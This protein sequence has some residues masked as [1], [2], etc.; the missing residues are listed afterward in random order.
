MEFTTARE[1][2]LDEL[3]LFAGVVD[4]KPDDGL[5]VFSNVTFSPIES[6][7][8]LVASGG[9]IGQ[10]SSIEADSGGEGPISL[11]LDRLVR[12]LTASEGDSVVFEE[13]EE[14]WI[15]AKCGGKTSRYPT[16]VG[17]P[18]EVASPPEQA[19]AVVDADLL[20]QLLRTGSYAFPV[21][22]EV[23][24]TNAGAQLELEGSQVRTVSSDHSRLAYSAAD[25]GDESGN[26]E[27]RLLS[28][29]LKTISQ[30]QTLA[31]ASDGAARVFEKDN[32]L[33]FEFGK[34]LLV[35]SKLADRLPD[36]D[37]VIPR[38]CPIFVR[39]NR[40]LLLSSVRAAIP[41]A[42]GEFN[43]ARLEIT[44]EQIQIDASSVHGEE[45]SVLPIEEARGGPLT[46]NVNL[47]HFED[48]A[49]S[50][51]SEFATLEFQSPEKAFILRPS[52]GSGSGQGNDRFDHFCVGMP[53]V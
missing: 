12:W 16:R 7:C 25:T 27:K 46:L 14:H 15:V 18:P 4:R 48:F 1:H 53:L 52:D 32:H 10:R 38:N 24:V 40:D 36:Y 6:G 34:R 3:N 49:K 47:L 35:C 13:T 41:F 50:F 45:T 17:D 31:R 23:T 51:D 21:G 33:F 26:G 9:E 44:E 28:L 8:S 20:A 11:P 5:S 39:A 30:L 19:L 42:A 43:R 22:N 37:H 29:S 2:L